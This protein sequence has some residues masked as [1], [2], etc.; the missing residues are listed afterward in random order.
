VRS[1]KKLLVLA[2]LAAV[3][4][5]VAACGSSGSSSSAGG[6][7]TSSTNAAATTSG[8]GLVTPK[9]LTIGV[10]P[11]T[12]SSANLAIW[13]AQLKAAAAPLG[14]KVIVCNGNGVV[15]TMEACGQSFVTQ[16][17]NAIV[18]MA[19]GGPE[20]PQTFAQ[21]KAA[22]I[23]VMAE[24]TS[25]TPGYAKDY[26]GGVYGDDIVGQGAATAQYVATHF[27]GEPII[28]L[29]VTA[30]YGG[31]GYVNGEV[32]EFKK[33][34]TKFT[35]L[36]DVDLANIVA[37]MTQTAQAE[38]QA[39]SGNVVFLGFDDIDPSLF[40][41]VFQQAGRSKNVT[42]IVRYDD[43]TTV[44]LMRKGDNILVVDTKEYQ[45]IFDMLNAL[46]ANSTHGTPFP[47]PATTVNDPGATVVGIKQYAP[48]ATRYYPFAPALKAQL[49]IWAK[50]Y[51]LQPSTLT[52][53]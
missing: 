28:G 38:L 8:S 2:A 10:I 15:T 11:S 13:I 46:L 21:A 37:S 6:S 35:D 20:I 19:L 51:K 17:V 12:S 9:P 52:A 7:A 14:Y 50:T 36:R 48:G 22:G 23:P 25:V 49:A 39:H 43:P 32:A 44:A 24:G 3:A 27:K 40:Q 42:E 31:Q 30:N 5:G 1:F 18:T 53:P 4:V 33:L 45:H 26:T 16:K 47:S 29:E 34:G 41:P